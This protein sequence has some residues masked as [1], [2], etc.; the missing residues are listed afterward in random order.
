MVTDTPPAAMEVMMAE[1]VPN[2]WDGRDPAGR[3]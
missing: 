1:A 2:E 3:G